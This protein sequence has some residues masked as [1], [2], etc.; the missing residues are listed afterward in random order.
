MLSLVEH[1]K[2]FITSGSDEGD[3]ICDFP[4]AFSCISRLW[5]G[6]CSK[7]NEVVPYWGKFN[8]FRVSPFSEGTKKLLKEF[9]PLKVYLFPGY[10]EKM[11][12]ALW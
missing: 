11:G 10:L 4:F 9:S 3:N 8:L 1:E 7:I 12:W 6:I 2:S 5:K